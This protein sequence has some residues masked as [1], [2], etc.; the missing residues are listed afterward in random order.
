[1]GGSGVA[2]AGSQT[3]HEKVK[4]RFFGPRVMVLSTIFITEASVG[5]AQSTI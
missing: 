5:F 3:W 1:M 2:Y 4:G